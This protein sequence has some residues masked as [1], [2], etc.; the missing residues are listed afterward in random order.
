MLPVAWYV[1]YKWRK[2]QKYRLIRRLIKSRYVEPHFSRSP[3][4]RMVSADKRWVATV[5]IC[6]L[7]H[8][9]K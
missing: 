6:Q 5:P 8:S 3:Y 7:L 4:E 9:S 2:F 1:D